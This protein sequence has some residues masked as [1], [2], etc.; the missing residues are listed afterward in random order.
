MFSDDVQAPS[1]NGS[2]QTLLSADPASSATDPASDLATDPFVPASDPA[3][4]SVTD[5]APAQSGTGTSKSGDKSPLDILEEI[6][7]ESDAEAAAEQAQAAQAEA[8]KAA[9]LAE[10]ERQA[11]EQRARDAAM[12]HQQLADLKTIEE[13]PENQARV[14]QN[15]ARQRAADEAKAQAEGFGIFQLGHMKVPEAELT[16]TAQPTQPADS[17][18]NQPAEAV[19]DSSATGSA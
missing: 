13:T 2:D 14:Q 3:A 4:A 1:Q 9:K 7:Q 19:Q 15:E 18:N 17:T 5:A 8:E 6:L 12:L 16:Q 10:L 11:E